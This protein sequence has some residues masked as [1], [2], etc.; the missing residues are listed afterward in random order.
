LCVLVVLCGFLGQYLLVSGCSYD[1][2][3]QIMSTDP[4]VQACLA[5]GVGSYQSFRTDFGPACSIAGEYEY[6]FNI[7]NGV[8]AEI[9]SGS[10]SCGCQLELVCGSIVVKLSP[11]P[12]PSSKIPTRSSTETGSNSEPPKTTVYSSTPPKASNS[13]SDTATA[14]I[15][16]SETPKTT[17]SPSPSPKTPSLSS[18]PESHSKNPSTD[19]QPSP[20]D[21]VT[22]P[23]ELILQNSPSNSVKPSSGGLHIGGVPSHIPTQS[24]GSINNHP[25]PPTGT[26]YCGSALCTLGSEYCCNPSCGGTCVKNGG[27]CPARFCKI[28]TPSVNPIQN[29]ETPCGSVGICASNQVCCSKL[30]GCEICA[31]SEAACPV[32]CPSLTP[33]QSRCGTTICSANQTCCNAGCGICALTTAGCAG[34]QNLICAAPS[35]KVN[36]QVCGNTVCDA[37]SWCCNRSCGI[38]VPLGTYYC[39]NQFC[40]TFKTGA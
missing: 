21:G 14:T 37:N 1:D 40:G 29:L 24:P 3:I 16:H 17:V 12:V 31:S 2:Y 32:S 15:S 23:S 22:S 8:G 36:G 27:V 25:L 35:P 39:T 26:F 30:P 28:P 18:S 4:S 19:P 5:S 33:G 34:M 20:H 10:V 38:C 11:E 9:V 13:H 7:R 6:L